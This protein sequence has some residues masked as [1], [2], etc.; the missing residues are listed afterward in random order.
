M[1]RTHKHP[2]RRSQAAA[3]RS[4]ASILAFPRSI[5]FHQHMQA[6]QLLAQVQPKAAKAIV[7]FTERAASRVRQCK[8]GS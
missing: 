1:R 7:T 3:K 5:D 8:T 6:L 2:G 4:A